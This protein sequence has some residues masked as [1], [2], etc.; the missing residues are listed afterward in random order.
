MGTY[1]Q[2]YWRE[3][4]YNKENVKQWYKDFKTYYSTLLD[5][6]IMK[7]DFLQGE[8]KEIEIIITD[9]QEQMKIYNF[10]EKVLQEV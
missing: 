4:Y 1:N 7:K 8:R 6:E 9:K 2:K 3:Q 10:I 5:E